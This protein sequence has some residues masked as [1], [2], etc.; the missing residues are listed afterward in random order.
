[1][2]PSWGAT[3]RYKPTRGTLQ[4]QSGD[5]EEPRQVPIV[6]AVLPAIDHHVTAARIKLVRN[7]M[8]KEA[9]QHGQGIATAKSGAR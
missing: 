6:A 1:M 7:R 9:P 2:Q 8:G 3:N 5:G 4:L